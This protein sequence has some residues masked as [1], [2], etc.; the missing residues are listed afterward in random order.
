MSLDGARFWKKPKRR[1]ETY[2]GGFKIV[3]VREP[4]S[5]LIRLDFSRAW[6]VAKR[7]RYRFVATGRT[8]LGP[9]KRLRWPKRNKMRVRVRAMNKFGRRKW[10]T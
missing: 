7:W 6:K 8:T 10:Q 4:A 2:S 9:P 1:I 5:R 3:Y